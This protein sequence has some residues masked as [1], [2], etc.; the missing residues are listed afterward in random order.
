MRLMIPALILSCLCTVARADPLVEQGPDEVGGLRGEAP[1]LFADN[2]VLGTGAEV[3]RVTWW[4][5]YNV[6]G[7]A[8]TAVDDFTIRFFADDSGAPALI[9]FA[10][11]HVGDPGRIETSFVA[12]TGA[13]ARDIYR[14]E[15]AIPKTWIDGGATH[16]LSI[17][18]S[19]GGTADTPW[20]WATADGAGDDTWLLDPP[21]FGP[22]WLHISFADT[23]FSLQEPVPEPSTWISLAL[24][25]LVAILRRR[26]R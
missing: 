11:Y 2:F 8:R 7:S 25:G 22:D 3:G 15:A 5:F 21:V 17:Q 23:A 26:S 1:A 16:Y 20:W 13:N 19:S 9:P 24:A 18:N 6:A 12:A 4:G 14:Y 10:S